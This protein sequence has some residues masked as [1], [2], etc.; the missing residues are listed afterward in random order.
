MAHRGSQYGLRARHGV[1]FGEYEDHTSYP[2]TLYTKINTSNNI[3]YK[4]DDIKFQMVL[5][6]GG[7]EMTAEEKLKE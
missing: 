7:C 1:K 4:T 2:F 3:P 6:K 5:C